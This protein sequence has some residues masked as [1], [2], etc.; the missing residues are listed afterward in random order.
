M[1][2]A[3]AELQARTFAL[4]G[5]RARR[6]SPLQ[7]RRIRGAAS[8]SA[9]CRLMPPE[10]PDIGMMVVLTGRLQ[11]QCFSRRIDCFFV[12]FGIEVQLG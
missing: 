3:A 11:G 1:T 6:M 2:T 12:L 10:I 7:A 8:L 9:I 5:D 4:E